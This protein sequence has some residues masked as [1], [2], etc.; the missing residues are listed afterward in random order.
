MNE[1]ACRAC[2][3]RTGDLVLDLGEQKAKPATI[4]PAATTGPRSGVPAADVA[5]LV[6]RAGPACSRSHGA[7]GRGTEP[8]ALVARAADAVERVAAAGLLAGGSR[9]AEYGSRMAALARAARPPRAHA[10]TVS[11]RRQWSSTV[12]A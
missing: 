9:V 4:S 10:S 3:A 7:E 6:V 1:H 12:S 2:R 11:G 5:V 8:A